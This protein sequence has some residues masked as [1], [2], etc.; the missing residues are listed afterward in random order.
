MNDLMNRQLAAWPEA[1]RRY[2][3]LKKTET[4]EID[5]GGMPE[6]RD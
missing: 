1:A 2:R 6:D 5:L 3:D 4:K